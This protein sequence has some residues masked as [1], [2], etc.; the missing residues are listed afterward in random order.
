MALLEE[1]EM[2]DGGVS[3]QKFH[4]K[5][6]V[7]GLSR[8]KFLGEKGEQ[9]LGATDTLLEDSAHGRVHCKTEAPELMRNSLSDKMSQRNRRE[10]Q[11]TLSGTEAGS[12]TET[13]LAGWT[14]ASTCLTTSFP[15]PSTV[16]CG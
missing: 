5:G 2:A 9:R 3:C 13:G 14:G 7:F 15:S 1:S 6:G 10:E 16:S 12:G 4:V 8:G 11:Q